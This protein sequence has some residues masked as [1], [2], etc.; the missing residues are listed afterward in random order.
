MYRISEL[1]SK[2]GMSRTA[3]LY[4][5]KQGLISGTRLENGYRVYN[6]IDLQRVRLI[7]QLLAGGLTL[8]ECKLCLE[9]KLDKQLLRNRLK[10][11]DEEIQRKQQSRYLLTALLGEGDLKAWH[12]D[13]D[14]VA[15]EA[16]L[17][18]LIMQALQRKKHCD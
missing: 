6:D 9:A 15:P 2:V 4:Y 5:E 13:L 18:W 16:H 7:Q 17:D 11:L 14:K 1:A 12:E 3:L 10:I 8:K